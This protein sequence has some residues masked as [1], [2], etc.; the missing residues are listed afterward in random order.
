VDPSYFS[1]LDVLKF[2]GQRTL[3]KSPE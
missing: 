1:I 3:F 2:W